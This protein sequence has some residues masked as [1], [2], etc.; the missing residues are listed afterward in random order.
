M[1]K[2]EFT[3]KGKK[4]D[5]LKQLDVKELAMLLPSEKKRRILTRGF[6]QQQKTLLKK[7][8]AGEQ[9]IKTHCRDMLV[10]PEMVGMTIRIH[11]GKDFVPIIIQDAMIGHYFGEFALTRKRVGHSAPG[12]GATKSSAHASVR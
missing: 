12:V 8:R 4:L 10:L 2:K 6:T 3:Y 5:E 1:A 7:I 9:N 11:N